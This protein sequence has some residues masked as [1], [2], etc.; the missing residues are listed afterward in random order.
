MWKNKD[1]SRH[2]AD[3]HAKD[4]A[5]SLA[6]FGDTGGPV[7]KIDPEEIIAHEGEAN[8]R[9]ELEDWKSK[10]L[11]ALADFQNYQ[12]RSLEN[13]KEAKRQGIISVVSHLMGVLDNFDLALQQDPS[14]ATTEQVMQGVSM[15]KS[16]MM[17]ALGSIG[18]SAIDPKP[19]DPFDPHRHQAI[20]QVPSAN[21]EPGSVA[22][23]FQVGY[24]L[25]E[26]VLR[27]AKTGVAKSTEAPGDP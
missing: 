18:V 5:E 9:T 23:C 16:Q 15:V 8:L 7:G 14:K 4:D 27:P 6:D 2:D 17:Q 20:A 1:Q 19:G 21:L 11:H 3:A 26:R 24:A 12:R 22:S 10:Y 13:E 25:G